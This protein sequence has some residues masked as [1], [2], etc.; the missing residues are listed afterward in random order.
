MDRLKLIGQFIGNLSI[1]NLRNV[2]RKTYLGRDVVE[3]EFD[4]KSKREF[5]LDDLK[6]I[7]TQEPKDLTV[8]RELQIM[9]VAVKILG[10][11]ADSELPINDPVEANLMYL[12][13]TVLPDSVKENE[14]KA[15]GKLFNKKYEK[16]TLADLDRVLQDGNKKKNKDGAKSE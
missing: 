8:L 13:N 12:L 7:A 15:Y 4:N 14:K 3:I 16:I 11:L 6:T 10:I 2:E 1:V 5:P 9:P